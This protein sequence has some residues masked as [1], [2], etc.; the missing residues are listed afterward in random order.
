MKIEIELAVLNL[1][2]R[3]VPAINFNFLDHGGSDCIL[4]FEPDR[5]LLSPSDDPS[6]F[7]MVDGEGFKHIQVRRDS[8]WIDVADVNRFF[9]LTMKT[10]LPNNLIGGR[11][12]MVEFPFGKVLK[13]S[14]PFS[15]HPEVMD[16]LGAEELITHKLR[17]STELFLDKLH[18][19][20][21]SS[22]N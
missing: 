9:I 21:G 18:G 2:G 20:L 15:M 3:K 8:K 13:N 11:V 10:R 5:L 16:R 19:S 4:E 14:E 22:A 6:Y 12:L 7:D 17:D 1:G